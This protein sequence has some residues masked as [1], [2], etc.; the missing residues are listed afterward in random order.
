[1]ATD[2]TIEYGIYGKSNYNVI[3]IQL[4]FLY[5]NSLTLTNSIDSALDQNSGQFDCVA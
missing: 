1:M 4:T 5:N 3:H 2:L